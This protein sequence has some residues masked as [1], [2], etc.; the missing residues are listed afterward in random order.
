MSMRPRSHLRIDKQKLQVDICRQLA[1]ES[2]QNLR[3]AG[4]VV[5]CVI[6]EVYLLG[7]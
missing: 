4:Q 3:D 5:P 2:A 6:D 1:V 7:T